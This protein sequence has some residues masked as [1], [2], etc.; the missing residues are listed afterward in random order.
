[1]VA[2]ASGSLS[3]LGIKRELENDNYNHTDTYSDISLKDMSDGTDE[4]IWIGNVNENKPNTS[5][6]HGM[7]E[8][9]KYDHRPVVS[10]N[11]GTFNLGSGTSS[12]NTINVFHVDYSRFW[13]SAKPTWVTITS[14]NYGTANKQYGSG[15]VTFDTTANSGSQRS[16]S[17]IVTFEVGTTGG[18]VGDANSTTTRTSTITQSGSGGGG[19]G[20]GGPGG[21]E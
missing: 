15:T 9:Y 20:G 17:L 12:N 19:G 1:M 16:G 4:S 8:F 14:G 13:V 21:D 5:T 6:P 3:M 7:S 2:P 10:T 18:G 11:P